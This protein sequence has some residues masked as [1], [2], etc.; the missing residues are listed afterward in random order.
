[1]LAQDD[2]GPSCF[3]TPEVHLEDGGAARLVQASGHD[4]IEDRMLKLVPIPTTAEDPIFLCES[5]ERRAPPIK[6]C[7]PQLRHR[8]CHMDTIENS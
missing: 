7:E 4:E 2:S 5:A 6:P 3:L 8:R 1:V